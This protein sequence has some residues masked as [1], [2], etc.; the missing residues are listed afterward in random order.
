[1][2]K[3]EKI[4]QDIKNSLQKANEEEFQ[5]ILK[6]HLGIEDAEKYCQNM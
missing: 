2:P 3:R 5:K 6:E 1:M 4:Q